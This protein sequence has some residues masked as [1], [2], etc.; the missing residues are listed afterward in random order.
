MAGGF[1]PV[2][3][4]CPPDLAL[5]HEVGT[6]QS[7]WLRSCVWRR[8][9]HRAEDVARL[10]PLVYEHVNMRGRYSFSVPE[11]VTRGELRAARS[12]R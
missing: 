2:R 10:S 1:R 5:R 7:G 12:Q 6:R 11:A 8:G 4:R 3:V 9:T